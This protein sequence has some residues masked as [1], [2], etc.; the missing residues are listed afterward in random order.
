MA[1][2]KKPEKKPSRKPGDKPG[3]K[4]PRPKPA[5]Q[6]DL[7]ALEQRLNEDD[8]LQ[9]KFLED[10][11]RTLRSEGVTLS[12]E[13]A[14]EL[15]SAVKELGSPRAVAGARPRIRITISITIRF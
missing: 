4:R 6:P 2:K 5:A 7:A 12:R 11:V 13:G 1:E 9:K 15:R 10:P 14:S 3:G 8:A